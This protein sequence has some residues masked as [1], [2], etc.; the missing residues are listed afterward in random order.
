MASWKDN[1]RPASFRGIPFKVDMSQ[2]TGGRRVA[3][4]E[5]PNRELPYSEDLGKVGGTYKVDGHL[6][7]DDYF[8]QR[9]KLQLACEQEGPGELIHP[10]YGTLQVQCGAFSL[11]EDTKEGRIVKVSMQFYEAGDDGYPKQIDN[12]LALLSDK[13]LSAIDAAKSKFDK[14]FSI[15]SMPGFAV[16]SARAG[17]STITELYKSS[18]KGIGSTAQ[19]IADLAFGV[20]NFQAELDDLMK[21]PAKL[22]QRM[23]DSLDLMT[24]ALGLPRGKLDALAKFYGYGSFSRPVRGETPTRQREKNN[25][26]AINNYMK[27]IA[28]A[29]ASE[30]AAEIEYDSTEEADAQRN[31]LVDVIDE[32]LDTTQDDDVFAAFKD[33]NAQLTKVLPDEDADLPNVQTVEVEQTTNSILLSYD[34]FQDPDTESDIIARNKII[35][36]GFIT[37]GRILEVVNGRKRA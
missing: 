28:I 37:Q 21:S 35:H 22:S 20:R 9:K 2:Y 11:D 13:S 3:F 16:D 15:A 5:Y 33:L 34:L 26:D 7:G 17:L 12:K 24:D 8:E 19:G 36:P 31:E 1:L 23:L 4:H 27:E 32:V 18:T 30:Q 6:L 10:Y 29:R 14:A 25:Q